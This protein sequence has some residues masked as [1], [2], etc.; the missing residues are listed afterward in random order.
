M[1]KDLVINGIH[2]GEHSF[3][4]DKVIDEINERC[5]KKGLNFVTIR[6]RSTPVP[7]EA[8]IKWAE[9]L[10]EHKIYFI[11][12]YTIQ[13][14]PEEIDSHLTAETVAKMREIA[15]EYF[16]GDMIGETGTHCACIFPGYFDADGN[17]GRKF[18]NVSYA[19]DM[20][21]AH[22]KYVATVSK[23]SE[24]DNRLGMPGIVSVEATALHKYNA[25]AGINIPML[26]LMCGNPNVLVSFLRGTA[27]AVD[28][29]LWGTYIA[30]EWYGGFR[31][32]DILKRK[33]LDLSYKYGYLAGSNAFCLES[34]DEEVLS[35][36]DSYLPGTDICNDYIDS[37]TYMR[38]LI[39]SDARPKGGPKVKVAFVSGLHDSWGSF[40]GSTAWNQFGR[41]EWG[42]NEAEHSWRIAEEIG[43]GRQWHEVM[44]YGDIDSSSNPAYGMYDVIPVEADIEK[45]CRYDYLIFL[46]WNSMTDENMD[47]ITE[48]VRRG[49]K[50]LMSVA[51]L[52]KS[53]VRNGDLDLPSND[54]L[55]KLFGARYT[56]K[57]RK[58]NGGIK[59]EFNS[60]NEDVL[61]PGTKSFICDPVC[62]AGYV[63]Y[64]EFE[65]CGGRKTAIVSENFA[66][67]DET[68]A[69]ST[70]AVIENRFG[71]G[72]ATLVTSTNYPGH[73][74]LYPLYRTITRELISASART[75][76]IKVIAS[77]K[78]RYSVYEGNKIYL[79]NTDY[80]LPI[81]VK[82]IF[83]GK[84][85][86]ETLESLE[87]RA[88]QL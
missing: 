30:H 66:D 54:K 85:R 27:R 29:K 14:M 58:T 8:F 20:E 68:K 28:S 73:P 22:N 82:I 45:L 72:I 83:N 80:D 16:I 6:T 39:K 64:A 31:H 56:G 1:E 70:A 67:D 12:L 51:H 48:Y 69:Q 84:E 38:D 60:L 10:A 78:L 40:G 4:V 13:S 87:L 5:V 21:A 25:E 18:T 42:Y 63:N 61:Y 35:Y 79:L 19:S 81:T 3:D 62:S 15:G 55:E 32:D 33:R 2:I 24:I 44:N 75:C 26:E 11:F 34:G 17:S 36:G 37:L 49:G 9:Y 77:D 43:S 86:L 41:E 65:L 57:L 23:C 59:F 50:L 47:K 46:G 52:N 7:Q 88:I 71:N 53:V 74:A 76:D